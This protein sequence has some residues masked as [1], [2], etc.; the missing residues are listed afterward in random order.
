[1]QIDPFE[2]L[3]KYIPPERK[4][5]DGFTSFENKKPSLEDAD[6]KTG[7]VTWLIV[8]ETY[9]YRVGLWFNPPTEPNT[10][11]FWKK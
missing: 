7:M 5:T 9:E 10:K 11:V 3:K 4:Q 1:M 8:R 6:S 2:Q